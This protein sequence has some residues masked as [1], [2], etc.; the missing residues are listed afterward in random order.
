MLPVLLAMAGCVRIAPLAVTKEV[1]LAG[2]G[3]RG[4]VC[5]ILSATNATEC[6][7]YAAEELGLHL[8]RILGTNLLV[9]A[10]RESGDTN[11]V[12]RLACD[13]ALGSDSYRLQ[14]KPAGRERVI[15]G[16]RPRGVMMGV[17]GLLADPF[18]FRW[19]TP[20]V[21]GVPAVS[22]IALPSDLDVVMT[23][24]LEYR[25][26]DWAEANNADWASRNRL[27]MGSGFQTK[28]GGGIV[29]S[30]DVCGKRDDKEFMRI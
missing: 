6:E 7:R 22:R 3:N 25:Q 13:P 30:P 16:G 29:F 28:H 24:K 8:G 11:W 23:P 17:Y 21:D 2:M 26:T 12:I 20:D 5:S 15:T 1:T 18:G 9:A 4:P 27:N 10:G 14:M 19:Y